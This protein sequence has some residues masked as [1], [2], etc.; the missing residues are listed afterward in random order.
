MI[1]KARKLLDQGG[2]T[3]VICGENLTLTARERGVKPLADWLEEG[4]NLAGCWAAD[5]VVGKATAYL[6]CLLKVR[7]VWARVMSRPALEVLRANGIEARYEELAE[8]I[9]NRRGDGM[10][11]FE[12]AVLEAADPTAAW[13]LIRQKLQKP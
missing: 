12:Q 9:I 8:H 13:T 10:C 1:E 4:R 7:G 11:P 6:Y 2:Y 5:K 3:C